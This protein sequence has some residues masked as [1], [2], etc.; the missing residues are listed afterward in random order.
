M[1]LGPGVD[2][3][4]LGKKLATGGNHAAYVVEDVAAAASGDAL[5]AAGK[6]G[7]FE[8][9]D[10]L[11]DDHSVFFTIAEIVMNGIRNSKV[12]WGE[13]AVVYGLGLLGR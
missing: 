7:H 2:K 12:Q 5:K 11:N 8:V 3:S 10:G 6:I 4:F 1:G 9:P 13:C